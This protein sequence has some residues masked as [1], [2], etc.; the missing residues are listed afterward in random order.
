MDCSTSGFPVLHCL[1]EFAQTHVHWVGV[2][3]Q[4]SHPSLPA[5]NLCQHHGLFLMSWPFASGSQS[6]GASASTSVLPMKIQGWLPL[7]FT[8]Q[9]LAV[10]VTPKSLLQHHSSNSSVLQCSAFFMIQLSY[11][12][13]TIGKTIALTIRTFVCKVMSLLFNILS[14]FV[15]A[16]LPRRKCLNFM[17]GVTICSDFIA[18]ENKICHCF[19]FF[20][21]YLHE[22]MWPDVM[23]LVFWML[24]LKPAFS[25]SSFTLI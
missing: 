15:I 24:S 10:Q 21:I 13:K 7:V 11:A 2:A 1:P 9:L 3:T 17:A 18:Q 4:P 20:P 14:R 5:F 23:I 16:L 6:I 8:G 19:N 22:I 12:Y 25:P